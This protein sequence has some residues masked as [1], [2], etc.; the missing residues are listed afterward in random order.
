MTELEALKKRIEELEERLERHEDRTEGM[1][2]EKTY[3]QAKAWIK[4]NPKAWAAIKWQAK[5]LAA[6]GKRV[7]IKRM[8]ENLR[9]IDKHLNDRNTDYSIC[10][11]YSACLARFLVAECPEVKPYISLKKSKVDRYFK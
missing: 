3:T 11:S 7:S 1:S 6:K 10:N 8:L 2:A 4:Q 9:Y 5:T